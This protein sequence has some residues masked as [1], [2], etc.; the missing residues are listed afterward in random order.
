MRSLL[1][2]ADEHGDGGFWEE[3]FHILTDPAH[4]IAELA[5]ELLFLVVIHFWIMDRVAHR[6]ERKH[7]GH[8]KPE[9]RGRHQK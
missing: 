8:K 6:H 2:F 4:W 5:A 9:R 3:A 1:F 7:N